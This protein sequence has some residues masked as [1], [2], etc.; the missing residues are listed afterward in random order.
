MPG[1]ARA[2]ST[3]SLGTHAEPRRLLDA[4]AGDGEDHLRLPGDAAGPGR[5][6]HAVLRR[7]DEPGEGRRSP[8]SP[9]TSSSSRPATTST[10]SST[11]ASSTQN[12]DQQGYNGIA[13]D[14]VVVFALR[15]GNPKKIKGWNDLIK[16]GVQVVTPN[17]FSSG[18]AKWNILAAYG[19]QRHLGKTD[20]QAI[21]YVAA[22]CS[23][24]SSRRTRRAR[25]RR[26]R[27]SRAR[28][29]C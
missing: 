15:D 20:A 23:R 10:C 25:T 4:E 18:S 8:A 11:R 19:A 29:T 1:L 6:L 16:P 7:L 28:A 14:T 12:W 27:S 3:R 26:T 5:Q 22:S 13:A 24:T 2:A 21:A 17:P 9:P